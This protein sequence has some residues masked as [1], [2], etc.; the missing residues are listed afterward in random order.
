MQGGVGDYTRQIGLAL[1]ELGCDVDVLTSTRAGPVAG[2]TV[3]P[4][5]RDWGWRAWRTA[6]T[7]VQQ[8]PPDILHIQ[9]Q[10]AAYA[11]QPAINLLPWRL[12]RLGARRPRV[13]VTFHDLKVPYVFPKAGPLRHW[14]VHE[15]AR[16]SDAAITTNRE[17][18]EALRKSLPK[19]PVLIPIGSNIAP[20]LPEGFDR[21]A[22]RARWG[23]GHDD[24]LICFFGFVNASKGVDTLLRAVSRLSGTQAALRPCLL[25]IG[26][27]TGSSDPTN[28]A[29]LAQIQALIE[30]LGLK[31]WVRWTG[32]VA[33]Q[34]VSASFAAADLCALPYRDGA[35]FLHGTLHAALAHGVPVLTTR[36]RLPLPELVHGEN[37]Y[38]VPPEDPEALAAA[39]ADLSANPDVRHRLGAGAQALSAGFRWDRIA[40]DTLA[41]YRRIGAGS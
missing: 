25:M 32:F 35:S 7:L 5:V 12:R 13:A 33:P 37:V 10:A 40:A 11:M 24:L 29:Y 36:P 6:L 34:E 4:V 23:A 28:V 17:D 39:I 26:G 20:S 3:H 9:Y 27:Q 16:R 15:L 31:G 8:E 22:W 38:L 19:P 14:I 30:H 2:L 1:R 41:L 21:D 18:Y